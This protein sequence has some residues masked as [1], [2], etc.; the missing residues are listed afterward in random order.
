[1]PQWNSEQLQMLL[2]EREPTQLFQ[3]ALTL[4]EDLGMSYLGI[5]LHLQIAASRPHIILYNNYPPAW[6]ARYADIDVFKKDP[7]V[8]RCHSTTLPV[9]WTDELF[10]EVPQFRDAACSHGLRHGWT[11]SV[12]DQRHN[13][14]QLSVARPWGPV[15]IG[16]FYEQSPRVLWL[17]NSLHALLTEHHL[18]SLAPVPKLSG[19]ELEVL[20]WSADGKTAEAIGRILTLST[21]TINFHIRS[22]IAKTNAAN[23]AGAI[24]IAKSCGLI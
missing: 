10:R 9:L 19:R 1:M 18:A 2:A 24:A 11:Q 21:S 5:T 15:D 12:H 20:K 4:V 16:E 17:C 13:E 14:T 23:K 6:N 8:S 7:V 22:L 3:R